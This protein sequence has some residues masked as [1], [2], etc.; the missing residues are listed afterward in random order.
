MSIR[1]LEQ[2]VSELPYSIRED[3]LGYALSVQRAMP[4]ILREA[5]I[6][7]A[8]GLAEQIVFVSGIKKLYSVTA[9]SFWVLE[10]SLEV[11]RQADLGAVRVAGERI[12]RGS[13]YYNSLST[14]LRDFDLLIEDLGIREV[15]DIDSLPE[16]ARALSAGR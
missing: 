1:D 11:A 3:V 16:L 12:D 2:V 7:E 15:I 8:D 10:N 9:S 5:R 13:E 4:E 6:R 14:L